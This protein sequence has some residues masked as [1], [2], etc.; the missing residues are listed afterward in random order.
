[1]RHSTKII[2]A[3][4]ILIIFSS[5]T[6]YGGSADYSARRR[7]DEY[8]NICWE[9]EKARL[10]NLAIHLQREPTLDGYIVVYAGR[11]SCTGEAK[12]RAERAKEWIVKRGVEDDRV[13]IR[14]GGYREDV[15]TILDIAPIGLDYPID[16]TLDPGEAV[17]Y[18]ECKDRIYEP[19]KC[20]EPEPV[21]ANSSN[22]INQ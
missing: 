2:C 15:T 17:I 3:V 22:L 11:R 16:P 13:I 8:G 21:P 19:V 10:D 9:D 7:F 18:T 20:D 12:Y 4:L 1:M 14:D 5:A 6:R